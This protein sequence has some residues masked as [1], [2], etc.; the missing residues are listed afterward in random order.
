MALARL[1]IDTLVLYSPGGQTESRRT[2]EM[3]RYRQALVRPRQGD[4]DRDIARSRL[5]E[6]RKVAV[7]R[8]LAT[9]RG[10]LARGFAASRA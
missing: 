9:D 10:W 6:R 2:F 8:A 4:S 7:L 5:M 1:T 3:F